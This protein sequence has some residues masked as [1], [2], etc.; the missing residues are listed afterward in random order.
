MP[1]G[2]GARQHLIGKPLVDHNSSFDHAC[3]DRT[4]QVVIVDENGAP[5]DRIEG[6]E[7]MEWPPREV[8][9]NVAAGLVSPEF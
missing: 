4:V 7:V 8:H 3:Y 9:E 1:L 2:G 6:K 5:L